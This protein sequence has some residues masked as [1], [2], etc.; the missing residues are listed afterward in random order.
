MTSREEVAI[1][2]ALRTPIAKARKGKFRN[3]KNDE[4]VTTAIRGVIEKTGI[5]PNAIQEVI[6]G[7]CLS[8]MEGSLAARMGALRAGVPVETPVMTVN[9][10]CASGMESVGLI[11]E[12]IRSGKIDI[13]L[14]G[15]FESMSSHGLPKE[16]NLSRDGLC[17]DAMDC[18][19]PFGEVSEMLSKSLGITRIESDEYAL[20]S[21]KRALDATKRGC[22]T[23]E[24][25]PMSIGGESVKDDEGIRETSLE[26]IRN[27]KP[28]FRDDGICTSAN[29]SQLSD[30]ASAIL[31]MRRK[32]ADELGLPVIAEFVDLVVMGL[33]PRDMGLGPVVAIEKLLE[34]N[35]LKKDE[36]SCFEIN[37]AFASQV[38][39]CLQ[40]LGVD[41]SK[42]NKYGGAI[43]L[44]HPLGA[45]GA[46]IVCTLLNVMENESSGEYGVA[47]LCVGSGYGIAALFKKC[48]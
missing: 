31:L 45:S 11:A 27:L 23:R 38:L 29:S 26:V 36:I 48:Y 43:A 40:R 9:R 21:Q 2:C 32:K 14:A 20:M 37:E 1:V 22:F 33:K 15:G 39:C 24:V 25:V 42:V 5:D 3:L 12:K 30:G 47:S 18:L 46:R 4:L 8:S 6:L 34:R 41:R 17:E 44:G 28:V 19:L 16:Y 7:H 10:L 13:G 35:N